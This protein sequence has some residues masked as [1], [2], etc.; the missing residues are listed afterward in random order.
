MLH[1]EELKNCGT[2]HYIA[3]TCVVNVCTKSQPHDKQ[4]QFVTGHTLFILT[5]FYLLYFILLLHDFL[6]I[7]PLTKTT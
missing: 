7:Y 1:G 4:K 2:I 5:C 6:F 3:T